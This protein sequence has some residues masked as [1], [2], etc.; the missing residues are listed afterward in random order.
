MSDQAIDL[1][2]EPMD[3]H[4]ASEFTGFSVRTLYTYGSTGI[5]PV[6]KPTGGKLVFFKSELMAFMLRGKRKTSYEL[7]DEAA[8]ILSTRG[9][10]RR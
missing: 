10:S 3:V 2:D 7:A 4:K 8:K 6:H 9:R 1:A 5:I